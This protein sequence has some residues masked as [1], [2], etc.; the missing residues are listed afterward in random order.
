MKGLKILYQGLCDAKPVF[1]EKLY[2]SKKIRNLNGNKIHKKVI[3]QF[4]EEK[5]MLTLFNKQFNF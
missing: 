2:T 3:D 4:I 5:I 1:G